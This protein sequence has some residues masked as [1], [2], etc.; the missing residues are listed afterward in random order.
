MGN[1][2]QRLFES[3]G[4][5]IKPTDT[6]TE[7]LKR[8]ETLTWL[9]SFE[10]NICQEEMFGQLSSFELAH[11][12]MQEAAYCGGMRL[13]NE[14]NFYFL[15][16]QYKKNGKARILRGMGCTSNNEALE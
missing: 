9:C 5:N 4:T 6:H 2:S 1:L 14:E 3:V 16:E 12:D 11:P 10:H 7:R 15:Y 8:I 13:G